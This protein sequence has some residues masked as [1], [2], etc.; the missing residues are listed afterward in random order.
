MGCG[1]GLDPQIYS[2]EA[3]RQY[4]ASRRL[5]ARL[6]VIGALFVLLGVAAY[7]LSP[8]PTP[9][10]IFSAGGAVFLL[11]LVRTSSEV[12]RARSQLE[13]EKRQW[14]V[15]QGQRVTSNRVR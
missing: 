7:L 4:R 9:I 14:I 11:M 6:A 12:S 15:K 10:L 13:S 8:G 1:M 2:F 3:V 5:Y